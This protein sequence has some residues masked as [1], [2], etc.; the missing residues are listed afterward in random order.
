MK[1][2]V[3]SLDVPGNL[4]WREGGPPD[5]P[6]MHIL[7]IIALSHMPTRRKSSPDHVSSIHGSS[8]A[9]GEFMANNGM[10]YDLAVPGMQILVAHHS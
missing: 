8:L 9:S 2:P 5:V 4:T 10:L 3:L 6:G 7:V 1:L